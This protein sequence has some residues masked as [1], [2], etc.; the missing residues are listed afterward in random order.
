MKSDPAGDARM[1]SPPRPLQP[2][3]W[4]WHLLGLINPLI[5]I[6]GNLAGGPW[7]AAGLLFMLGLGP[8]LDVLLGKAAQPRPPRASG[9]PFHVL[10]YAHAVFQ[11]VAVGTLLA[12]ALR[13]PS[14][15]IVLMASISTALGLQAVRALRARHTAQTSVTLGF[16]RTGYRPVLPSRSKAGPGFRPCG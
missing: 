7:V 11:L 4:C 6:G 15:W 5:V 14:A 9:T 10:L 16:G 13:E 8:L 12:L 2:E 1:S 3:A